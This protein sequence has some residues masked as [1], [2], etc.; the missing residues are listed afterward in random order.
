MFT[1]APNA[2]HHWL[3]FRLLVESVCFHRRKLYP[4][5]PPNKPDGFRV[6]YRNSVKC[7]IDPAWITAAN[8][9]TGVTNTVSCIGI[10]YK[11]GSQLKQNKED[12]FQDFFFQL[13]FVLCRVSN[14]VSC[15]SWLK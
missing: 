7:D 15:P 6:V 3:M 11:R 1:L 2:R 14:S 12:L 8:M 4:E 5:D 13:F 10:D 9:Q